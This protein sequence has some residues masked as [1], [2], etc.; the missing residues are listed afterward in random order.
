MGEKEGAEET[1]MSE[2]SL[3][4]KSVKQVSTWNDICDRLHRNLQFCMEPDA[5]LLRVPS[6]FSTPNYRNL[7]VPKGVRPS[8]KACGRCRTADAGS[9]RLVTMENP[10]RGSAEEYVVCV[11]P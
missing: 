5:R 3:A 1:L 10:N 2:R 9:R 6:R 8:R 4:E 7:V 11:Y